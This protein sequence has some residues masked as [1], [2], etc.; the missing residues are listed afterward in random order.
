MKSHR[1]HR[2]ERSWR[3]AFTLIELLVVIAIIAVLA[4]ILLP[5]L[6]KAKASAR[7]VECLTRVKQ[8]AMAFESYSDDNEG[9]I[10]REGYHSSGQVFWNNWAQVQDKRSQD[11]WYNALPNHMRIR[12]A[13]SYA[14]P[15]ER[16]PF[17]GHGSFFHCPSA[18]I[19]KAAESPAYQIALFSVAMNSQ[20]IEFTEAPTIPFAKISQPSHTVLFMDNLLDDEPRVM[21][22]QA[23]DN[24]GQPSATANRFAGARHGRGG[25]MSFADG[26][27]EWLGG[28]KVVETEGVNRG[29]IRFPEVDIIWNLQTSVT[30]GSGPK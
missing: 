15:F 22:E 21:D 9:L 4:A 12:P 8:W 27:A 18:R 20:L 13:S 17:Y 7:R 30:A 2:Q 16:V 23:W 14:G 26:H 24:L 3:S 29:W 25:N 19:P 28:T 5:I 6:A 11:V 1:L 10:A